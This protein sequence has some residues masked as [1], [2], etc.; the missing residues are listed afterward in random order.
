MT[1]TAEVSARVV[2]DAPVE[3]VYAALAD[4]VGQGRW[5]PLTTVRVVEGD[6]GEGSLIRAITALGPI[7][8]VDMMRVES[9]E[10]P[11][12]LRVLHCGNLIRGPGVFRCQRRRDG[13]TEV[14]W[15]D[16]LEPP[17]GPTGKMAWSV[18]RPVAGR[19]MTWTLRRLA[20]VL[21]QT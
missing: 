17:G 7:R 4:W 14:H 10:P 9:V 1:A 13:R 20:R 15:Q 2:V 12:R 18:L 16:F 8:L 5:I 21:E 19:C 3:R 11:H 6:G